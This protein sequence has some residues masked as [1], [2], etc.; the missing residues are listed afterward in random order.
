MRGTFRAVRAVG[1]ESARVGVSEQCRGNRQARRDA[2][3]LSLEFHQ[4]GGF[5]QGLR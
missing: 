5:V 2:H 3:G 1:A 4:H